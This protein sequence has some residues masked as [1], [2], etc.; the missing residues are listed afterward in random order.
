MLNYLAH[1]EKEKPT[2]RAAVTA[3]V[4]FDWSLKALSDERGVR[5]ENLVA[6]LASVGGQMCLTTVF[7]KLAEDGLTPQQI[8]MLEMN[9]RDGH[10][11]YYGDAPNALLF[12]SEPAML[13]LALGAAQECGGHVSMQMLEEVAGEVA[14]KVGHGDAFFEIDLPERHRTDSPLNWAA[15]FTPEIE[16][17]CAM[18]ELPHNQRPTM[19][20]MALTNAIRSGKDALDPTISARIAL[21]Y[22]FRMAKIDPRRLEVHRRAA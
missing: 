9:G 16:K 11:Y 18:Y 14:S 6:M 7:H 10:T 17:I 20:G 22:G 2:Q 15:H 8:G 12:E 3:Q 13:S 21:E 19:M 4:I 1:T 5:V